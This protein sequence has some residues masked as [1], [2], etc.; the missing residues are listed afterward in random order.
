ME[1]DYAGDPIKWFDLKS[2]E[3]QPALDVI[4]MLGFSQLLHARA[5]ED[6]QSRNWLGC[7]RRMLGFYGSVIR[8]V[9]SNERPW[10][11]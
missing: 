1:V 11:P 2:R 9:S 8:L 10:L 7:L 3:I 4:A 6:M 5:A